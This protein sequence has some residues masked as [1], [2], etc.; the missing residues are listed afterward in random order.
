MNHCGESSDDT[1]E[2]DDQEASSLQGKNFEDALT[3][4][5]EQ[6]QRELTISPKHDASR[7]PKQPSME[8]ASD[9]ASIE[10]KAKNLFL[11]GIEHEQSRK[12]YE[13]I[14]FY[15][16]AVQ[17]VP[18]IEVRLYESTKA[19]ARDKY[20]ADDSLDTLDND[21]SANNDNEN[22]N[23]ADEEET[24]LFL[25]LSKIVNPNRVCYPKFEQSTTHLSAL[26][27]EIVLFILKWVVSSELDFRSLEMFSRVCRG[28]YITARDKE[29]WRLAC[30]RVWG[31]NCGTCEPLYQSWRD[32]YLHRPRLRYNG[33]YISKTS[34]IRDGEN[35]FQDRF[36]RPWHLVEYYRYFRFFPEGRVL[37]LTST[38]EAQSC[39]N[40]L[41]NR[42]PRNPSVLIGHYRLHDN[43]VTL[44]LKKQETKGV[45]FA[46]RRK[47]REPVHDSGEQTFHIEF[48]IQNHHRRVNSQLRW[49][50]YS[51]FTKYKNGVEAK[52]WLKEPSV[53]EFRVS[54]IGGRYPPLKFS[55]VKSYTQ[56]SE[57][58][59]Q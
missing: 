37:M 32:M 48:E 17:L 54:P 53:R 33:C 59:L 23:E 21:L 1:D 9:E 22:Y 2:G 10:S 4:F 42:V 38:D 34:Y 43:C 6:W 58:P 51:I 40:S 15:K 57:A 55:R 16:R 28:F 46:Y 7:T 56:E 19:K 5:R 39:V 52:I 31:V 36:Y 41:R 14:Q 3:S 49:I 20:D 47:K 24:D 45:N 18:D 29:I 13:A 50:S 25:K 11:K 26:P 27:M 8:V 12:F 35:N 44:M 30:V